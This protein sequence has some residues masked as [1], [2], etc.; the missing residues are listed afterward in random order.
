M[1]RSL[2]QG[3]EDGWYASFESYPGVIGPAECSVS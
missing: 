3:V 1:S 2:L